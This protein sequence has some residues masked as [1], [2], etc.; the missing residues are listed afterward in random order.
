M[1]TTLSAFFLNFF[2]SFFSFSQTGKCIL[3]VKVGKLNSFLDRGWSGKI[4]KGN[5][6]NL[7]AK[8]VSNASYQWKKDGLPIANATSQKI[9]VEESGIYTVEAKNPQCNYQSSQV[10]IY[11]VN[12]I[13]EYDI[14]ANGW[15]LTKNKVYEA[16][17]SGIRLS[18][19]DNYISQSEYQWQRDGVDIAKSSEIAANTTGTYSVRI[20]NG[21]CKL[22]TETIKVKITNEKLISPLKF[23]SGLASE[24]PDN[25]T[26]C[27]NSSVLLQNEGL[28]NQ[29]VKWYKDDKPYNATPNNFGMVEISTAGKYYSTYQTVAGCETTSKSV[30]INLGKQI[31]IP[32]INFSNSFLRCENTPI[33]IDNFWFSFY[34]ST[35]ANI[36]SGQ[37]SWNNDTYP[38]LE[39][40]TNRFFLSN[41]GNYTFKIAYQIN[42]C[43]AESKTFVNTYT[44]EKPPLVKLEGYDKSQNVC[45]NDPITLIFRGQQGYTTKWFKD[46]KEITIPPKPATRFDFDR[47]YIR[48]S[49]KYHAVQYQ[50]NC[51]LYSDT[52]EVIFPKPIPTQITQTVENCNSLLS[53]Q[54]TDGV[55][56]AWKKN[57]NIIPSANTT[58]YKPKE[59][60]VYSLV[61]NQGLCSYESNKI[62]IGLG[63]A[64]EKSPVCVGDTLKFNSVQA[65][66]YSWTG[67]NNFTSTQQN[68]IIPNVNVRNNGIYRLTYTNNSGCTNKDSVKVRV[69]TRPQFTLDR[70]STYC[71]GGPI[72]MDVNIDYPRSS[73]IHYSWSTPNGFISDGMLNISPSSRADN[74]KYVV[75]ATEYQSGC[76]STISTQITLTE[77]D[78]KSIELVKPSKPLCFKN[79]NLIEFR[80]TGNWNLENGEVFDLYQVNSYGKKTLLASSSNSPIKLKTNDFY[81]TLILK[82]RNSKIES[83][84]VKTESISPNFYISTD[85]DEISVCKGYSVKLFV[86]SIYKRLDKIQWVLDGKDIP[87]ATQMSYNATKSGIYTIKSERSG[88]KSTIDGTQQKVKVKI[89]EID[90]IGFSYFD[91]YSA[92]TGKSITLYSDTSKLKDIKYH[93]LLD[94]EAIVGANKP[95]HEATKSGMYSLKIIQDK[96]E[97]ISDSKKIVIGEIQKPTV[98]SYPLREDNNRV[99]TICDGLQNTLYSYNF[100]LYGNTIN[101]TRFQWERNGKD[102]PDAKTSRL[103]ITE[104]GIY[105]LKVFQGDCISLS[106]EFT[107]KKGNPKAL[108]LSYYNQNFCIDEE[109]ILSKSSHGDFLYRYYY[110]P[111]SNLKI[112]LFQNNKVSQELKFYE[113]IYVNE[114]GKYYFTA[115]FKIPGYEKNCTV[116]SDTLN[117]TFSGK[118]I[119][120]KFNEDNYISTCLDSLKL[121]SP[122]YL[123]RENKYIWRLNNTVLPKDT[124]YNITLKQSGTYQLESRKYNGCTYISEPFK[125][126]FS[127]LDVYIAKDPI[128]YCSNNSNLLFGAIKGNTYSF[129]NFGEVFYEWKLNGEKI[130]TNSFVSVSKSGVYELT[131]KQNT[132]TATASTNI[133]VIDLPKT[134]TPDKDSLF[135]CPDGFVNIEAPKYDKYTWLLNNQTYASSQSIKAN[136][137]GNYRV[138]LEK[139]N[140]NTISKPI[141]ISQKIILPTAN[142]SGGKEISFGDSTKIQIGLTSS[143]PWQVKLT[144]NQEFSI[145]K[146][147]FEFSVKPLQTTVYELGSVK[148]GCGDGKV[149]GKAEVKLIILGNEEFEGI[150]V[151]ISPNPT[152]NA[153][154]LVIES[155]TIHLINYL[156]VDING[157]QIESGLQTDK[158]TDFRKKISLDTLP[159]GTYLL[160]IM[161]GDKVISRKIIKQN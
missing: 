112:T 93:W 23:T 62:T 65:N 52:L 8:E 39:G 153:V 109:V 148:N 123:F 84:I 154:E 63:V 97:A 54:K 48:E 20:S 125:V 122:D 83:N 1:K 107:I 18:I 51:N 44:M 130:A 137:I 143:P 141:N 17:P 6:I 156:L 77:T 34:H 33:N 119:S 90:P 86:D 92:C 7:E 57:G 64:I 152:Q 161:V 13:D 70:A 4:C 37:V 113:D 108:N 43:K 21:E 3:P 127:K 59:S 120:Y 78:C 117:L 105:R 99:I 128:D 145:E 75:T 22:N 72:K 9:T 150:K 42:D 2:I 94:G 15:Y 38:L 58:E 82:S 91:G 68:P 155:T 102:I 110:D 28:N 147:P 55:T 66:S 104:E 12:A 56:Y 139:G 88:C 27:P 114:T 89:G 85:A 106:D 11:V 129:S 81:Y 111:K 132:C 101:D 96:C 26:I 14:R 131:A 80:L 95:Y 149:S 126:D 67:P 98:Y 19:Q 32:I 61:S 100:S 73:I 157:K 41:T 49:G 140:C 116:Y 158:T 133:T 74:G 10:I 138:W 40:L 118:T 159:N 53:I 25:L 35:K 24:V 45:P 146:T 136:S 151:N 16:C 144:N 71:L 87:N 115:S 29:E 76:T 121:S 135:I 103:D 160:K 30:E 134:L 60:G 50:S 47:I 69:G 46:N 36:K 31:P 142:I 5:P 79:E 124:L